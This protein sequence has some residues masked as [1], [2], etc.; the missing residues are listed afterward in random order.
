[1]ATSRPQVPSEIVARLRLA[2]LDLPEAYEET[3]WIGTRWRIRD[4]T[5]AHVLMI[6]AGWPPAYARASGVDG[7]ACLLTFRTWDREFDPTDFD[8]SPFFRPVW[9]PNIVGLILKDDTDWGEV[10]KLVAL[11][12]RVMAPKKLVQKLD[13]M[14]RFEP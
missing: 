14:R 9:W 10:S 11:S 2:A 1:M 8:R 6:D 7:P 12:Y 5:F 3:A 13:V 4:K